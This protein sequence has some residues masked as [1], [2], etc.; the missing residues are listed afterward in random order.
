MKHEDYKRVRR[1]QQRRRR[2]TKSYKLKHKARQLLRKYNLTLDE[3]YKLNKAQ[4]G[5]CAICR[6]KKPLAVDHDHRT[7]EVRGLLCTSCN[8]TLGWFER[9]SR[10]IGDY[11]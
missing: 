2:A 11:L 9:F 8:L 1:E 6:R 3:Y 10:E 7:G 5:K 4:K